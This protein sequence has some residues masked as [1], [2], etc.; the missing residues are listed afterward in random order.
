MGRQPTIFHTNDSIW[1]ILDAV[2]VGDEKDR[3]T[4]LAGETLHEFDHSSTRFAVEGGGGFVGQDKFGL[5]DQGTRD[6]NP[7]LLPARKVIGIVFNVVF[8]ANFG[9][10]FG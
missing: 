1:D 10:D 9:E 2:V 8:E 5:A 6:R 7:L 4:L 3:A